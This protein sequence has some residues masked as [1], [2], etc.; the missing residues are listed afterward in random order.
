MVLIGTASRTVNTEAV[1]F[2]S[3]TVFAL[4]QGLTSVRMT[5]MFGFLDD[6]SASSELGGESSTA[7][8]NAKMLFIRITVLH[9]VSVSSPNP[10]SMN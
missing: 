6:A 5:T 8:I 9:Q 7:P 10:T 4:L 3:F 2:G 1:L